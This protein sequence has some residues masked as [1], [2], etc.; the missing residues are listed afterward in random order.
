M[1]E[2]N[3]D[4]DFFPGFVFA[5]ILTVANVYFYSF[6]FFKNLGLSHQSVNNLSWR[7]TMPAFSVR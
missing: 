6:I 4:R 1:N 3:R 2:Q 5:L 7:C